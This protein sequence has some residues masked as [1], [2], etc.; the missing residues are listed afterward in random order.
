MKDK[1]KPF[2]IPENIKKQIREFLKGDK[3]LSEFKEL[4]EWLK[5]NNVSLV[6]VLFFSHENFDE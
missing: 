2:F 3:R 1:D 4:S 6:E 5:E